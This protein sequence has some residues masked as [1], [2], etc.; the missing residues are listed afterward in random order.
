MKILLHAFVKSR[1]DYCNSL[2]ANQPDYLLDRLQTV[3][4]AVARLYAG[5]GYPSAPTFQQFSEMTF[6]GC[7]FLSKLSSSSAHLFIAH[8]TAS[9]QFIY[10]TTVC[11]SA[12]PGAVSPEIDQRRMVT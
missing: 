12:V 2:L 6:T 8:C 11:P 7:V 5:V 3:L 10:P 4:N 9:P 1:I